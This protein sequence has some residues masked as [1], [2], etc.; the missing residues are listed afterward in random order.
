MNVAIFILFR[1]FPVYNVDRFQAIVINYFVCVVTGV[2]F[3]GG[4]SAFESVSFDLPWIPYSLGL[5][6]FFIGTFYAMALTTEYFSITVSSVASKISLAIPVL[7]AL[8]IFDFGSKVFDIWNYV[9]LVLSIV[10]IILA[11]QSQPSEKHAG[12]RSY[13]F[14]PVIVFLLGGLLDTTINYVNFKHLKPED[15]AI[16]PIFIFMTAATIGSI[17]LIYRRSKLKLRNLVA[18]FVLGLVNYFSVY[19]II[20]TLSYFQNDGALV[21]PLLNMGII[22]GSMVLSFLFF[23]EKMS[24]RKGIA[25]SIAI[26]SIYLISYQELLG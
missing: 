16:F 3:S 21:F 11:S 23:A 26:F 7:F 9:G 4:P 24:I 10:A 14:L 8:F 20:K 13:L 15:E 18:G 2:I 19:Y 22:L 17:V 12:I 5:G 1:M 25:I 6:F